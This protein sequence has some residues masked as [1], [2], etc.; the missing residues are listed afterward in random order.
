MDES[1]MIFKASRR[2]TRERRSSQAMYA[3]IRSDLFLDVE[4][5]REE[6]VKSSHFAI[7]RSTR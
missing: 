5:D 1:I 6:A 7:A 4:E 2:L 3:S